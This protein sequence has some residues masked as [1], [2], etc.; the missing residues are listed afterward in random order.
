MR[1]GVGTKKLGRR[2][3]HRQAMFKNMIMGL[4]KAERITTTVQK[5]KEVRPLVEKI[6]TWGKKDSVH[7]RRMVFR[8]VA[9]RDLV[10]RIFEDVAPRFIDRSGGYTRI[11]K[12]GARKGDGAEEAILELVDFKY[13]AKEK[14]DDKKK[15]AAKK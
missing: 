12:L 8:Y 11:L 3:E 13:K 5:A 4:F 2:S 6:V 1:H 7:A 14:K 15:K 10:K 9:D